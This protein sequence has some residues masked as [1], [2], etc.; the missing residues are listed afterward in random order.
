MRHYL[1]IDLGTGSTRAAIVGS[2]GNIVSMHSFFNRKQPDHLPVFGCAKEKRYCKETDFVF[3]IA[4]A[5]FT[6]SSSE[7]S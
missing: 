6:K 4:G 1:L 2:D 5:E 7:N 3:G